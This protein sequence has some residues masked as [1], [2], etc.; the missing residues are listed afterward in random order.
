MS[1]HIYKNRLPYLWNGPSRHL[2][3]QESIVD[4]S[5]FSDG[6]AESFQGIQEFPLLRSLP[7]AG[8]F[9]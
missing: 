4:V 7:F 2:F 9:T 6:P 8:K 5:V 3:S 1:L